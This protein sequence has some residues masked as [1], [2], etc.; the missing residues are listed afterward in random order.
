[1]WFSRARS[2]AL[3]YK[4]LH[5]GTAVSEKGSQNDDLGNEDYGI[6][7]TAFPTYSRNLRIIA[8]APQRHLPCTDAGT[9]SATEANAKSRC[10]LGDSE[11]PG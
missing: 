4:I 8:V 5:S 11:V 3:F 1:M 2:F 6:G 10:G 7:P 9:G